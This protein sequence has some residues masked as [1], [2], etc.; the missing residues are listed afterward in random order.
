VASRWA[1]FRFAISRLNDF[2]LQTVMTEWT[3][4]FRKQYYTRSTMIA[5]N[6]VFR[7]P[8]LFARY[9]LDFLNFLQLVFL[10][11]KLNSIKFVESKLFKYLVSKNWFLS[12]R[13]KLI[14][15]LHGIS[16]LRWRNSYTK[17]GRL[18]LL[19]HQARS[20]TVFVSFSLSFVSFSLSFV[21]VSLSGWV[22]LKFRAV[23]RQN[24]PPDD[25]QMFLLREGKQ[26]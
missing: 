18:E 19:L 5:S 6:F 25:L 2:C 22:G 3:K 1:G 26:K 9:Y 11:L 20:L 13:Q 24:L 8:E 23:I 4:V 7:E 21:S 14:F 17:L 12:C 10:M 15:Y 16:H